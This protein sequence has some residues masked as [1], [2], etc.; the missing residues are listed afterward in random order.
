MIAGKIQHAYAA[1]LPP[2]MAQALAQA[3]AANPAQKAPGSY[4]LQEE[5]LF[6][7][8]MQFATQN[9]QEKCAELHRDYID[10]Q[11]LLEG[12]EQI[13]YGVAGSERECG[14]WHKEEDYQLCKYI[15]AE[16]VLL[17]EP[18]MFA[19]FMPGEPHKPGC[20]AEKAGEIKKVVLKLH[21]N[22]LQA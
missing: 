8:V 16:Q 21:R 11:I 13:R 4:V 22:A 3:L 6:M 14:E 19:V 17:M 15:E 9:A 10:I 12:K 5:R 2:A 1:G 20:F 7:N 18:G